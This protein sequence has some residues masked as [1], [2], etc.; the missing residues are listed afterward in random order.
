M[1]CT[2]AANCAVS[3]VYTD[4]HGG[5]QAFEA[6]NAGA[7]WN[8]QALPGS[9]ELNAGG[10]AVVN[11]VS[12][13]APFDC[14]VAGQATD[15]ANQ[16]QAIVA[17]ESGGLWR[18]AQQVPGIS[19]NP[20]AAAYAVS[21]T[22]ARHCVAGGSFTDAAGHQ[23]GFLAYENAETAT[24]DVGTFDGAL[25]VAGNLNAGG[26]AAVNDVS[27]SQQWECAAGGFYTDAAGNT[28]GFIATQ[29]ARTA[30]TLALTASKATFG[31]E[32]SAQPTATVT[33]QA[34]GT[35]AGQVTMLANGAPACTATLA[36]GTAKCAIS[37]QQLKP[38]TYQLTATYPGA[39]PYAGSTSTRK[40]LTITR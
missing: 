15:S 4:H 37:P 29:S 16:S 12:C 5:Q 24:T 9:A 8:T 39:T 14:A 17:G 11:D 23:Q 19:D 10:N 30:T 1:A 2:A 32:Q 27:C 33:A 36:S 20:G 28:Q 6:D 21:C 40:T 25:R 31:R 26:N 7:G 22:G 13:G 3:G 38:G 34:G 18:N 35:P